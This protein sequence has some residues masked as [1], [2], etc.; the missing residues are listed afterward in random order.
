MELKLVFRRPRAALGRRALGVATT[1]LIDAGRVPEVALES[2]DMVLRAGD[3]AMLRC[4]PGLRPGWIAP[5]RERANE[6]HYSTGW[7]AGVSI[8]QSALL[9]AEE[10]IDGVIVAEETRLRWLEWDRPEEIRIGACVGGVPP[11]SL[12]NEDDPLLHL[13]V[14]WR[15]ELVAD[16]DTLS[17]AAK[18]FVGVQ[19]GYRFE[20]P[21]NRW[22]AFNPSIALSLGWVRDSAG[23][24]RWVD[25]SGAVMVETL[26]WQDGLYDQQP[27]KPKVEVGWGWIVKASSAGWGHIRDA[28]D[29]RSRCV[30]V[31]R[32]SQ[33]VELHRATALSAA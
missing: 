8:D 10:I 9:Q 28:Y 33:K 5:I 29:V 14:E 19:N 20:T 15:H 4:R 23:L 3:P 12:L 25:S 6:G 16:Y 21:G 13:C 30:C 26:L 31:M 11:T 2:L 24:F 18:H 27:P 17:G 22:L 32:K 1:E 7:E